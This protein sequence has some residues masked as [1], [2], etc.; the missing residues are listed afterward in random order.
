MSAN[1]QA[2]GMGEALARTIKDSGHANARSGALEPTRDATQNYPAKA[3]AT[4]IN[5]L[6]IAATREIGQML[7]Q[8]D[9]NGAHFRED[10]WKEEVE[11]AVIVWVEQNALPP[12]HAEATVPDVGGPAHVPLGEINQAAWGRLKN[13]ARGYADTCPKC[14]G[15]MLDYAFH[16]CPDRNP[17]PTIHA[18]TF[19][20]VPPVETSWMTQER[21]EEMNRPGKAGHLWTRMCSA[22]GATDESAT[23]VLSAPSGILC[24]GCMPF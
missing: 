10:R 13:V 20:V 2:T 12:A 17:D 23:F 5:H 19:P 21:I 1:G 9:Y 6:N 11:E 7:A 4:Q 22:C 24:D 3:L 14:G 8:R 15:I 16:R 18:T